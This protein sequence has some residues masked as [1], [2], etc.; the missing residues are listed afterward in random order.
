M[1][2]ILAVA[3]TYQQHLQQV[4]KILQR[5]D[6]RGITLN[7]EKFQF[8]RN[9]VKFCGYKITPAGYTSNNE[10]ARAIA[11]FPRPENI[12]DLRSFMGLVNQLSGLT[13]EL[14]TTTQAFRDLLK[15]RH[16]WCWTSQHEAAFLRAKS[17]LSSPPV[18]AFFDPQL[19][20]V[21]QT[22]AAKTR[23]L[24]FALLQRHGDDWR[25]VQCGSR[26]LTDTESRYA[27]VELE[28]AAVLWA[29]KKCHVYLAGMPH[30]DVVVDH[31]PLVAILN[32]K[33]LNAIDNPRLQRM[34]EKL[35]AY[36]FT[37]SWQKGSA[38]V[39][40]D[41]LS[42]AP[43][44]DP[45]ADDDVRED[46]DPLHTSVIAALQAAN[47]SEDGAQLAPLV[48]PTL[49]RI[50][51]AAE[52][53]SAYRSL[54]DLILAG[55]PENRYEAP[56][57]VRPYWGVRHQ[58][59]IDDG[60][61]VYGARLVI[62]TDLRRG[63]LERLHES[64]QGVERTKRRAR[65][66]VYWPGIDKDVA[67]TVTACTQCRHRLP[68][69]AREPM[70][71]E[72]DKPTRVFESVSA[73]YFHAGGHTYLVYVDRLSGWPYVTVCPR[74]ASADHLTRQLRMLFAQT[75]VPSVLRS[76]GGPQFA[77]STLRRFLQRWDVRHEM[78]SP[79]YPR[80]NGHAEACVKT[81]K[82]LVLAALVSGRLDDDQ[83]DRGLLELRNTP[84]A[85]GRSPA[86][87]LFGHPL[88]SGVPSHHGAFG[89]E[90]Q[91]AAAVCDEKAAETQEKAVRYHDA[92]A[93]QLSQLKIG[94]R[95]DLQDPTTGR[96]DRVGMIVGIGQRRT[97]L[98]RTASGRV[99]W[100]N[101]RY[102]RPYRPLLT[103]PATSTPSAVV[104]REPTADTP[105]RPASADGTQQPV[106]EAAT[107]D[108]AATA[109]PRRPRR[110]RRAPQRLHVRWGGVSYSE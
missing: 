32:H 51:A 95:V 109:A 36:S 34:R 54:R 45:V 97:Y 27:V 33:Q 90:W 73:D 87:V 76:D 56:P 85:D 6:D 104:T 7:S 4:I 101:R 49:E 35:S 78:S 30:F 80:S 53:D 21:L 62:P 39:I 28:L 22:D 108:E 25:L 2:D 1:D 8:P 41:A 9:E 17:V 50:R 103:E 3:P 38:H 55:F 77:S 52:R 83:L 74:T 57:A 48:D 29:C 40:P 68:S 12:T 46:D 5:C 94:S 24:G 92:S 66:S 88:R 31:R 70:W 93:C 99:L 11:D 86:Q 98:V 10:K 110:R 65:L 16:I 89:P 69:H 67:D 91:K 63:M 100:R 37:T 47:Q 71:R 107:A 19:P 79:H 75:G 105:Q 43:S 106:V 42:R 96:W 72:D 60:L 20:T 59:A 13:P 61:V 14:A 84:R 18:M 82:K 58:L 81:V 26:F 102:L 44:S 15:S 23:G 64:H